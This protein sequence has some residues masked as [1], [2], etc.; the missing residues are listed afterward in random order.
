MSNN[1]S[2]TTLVAKFYGV[3]PRSMQR[4]YKDYLSDFKS[5]DQKS[6]ARNWML[7][8]QNIGGYLSLD[9]TAFSNGDLYTIITNK[10]AKGK[11][12]AIIAMVK[13]TK[14]ETVIN[15]LRKIPLKQ[16]SKV[17]E[18]TLDMAGNMGLI[19]KK[20][21][22]NATLVIDRFHVQKLA[23]DA[24]QEIR[25]K[26]RW[27]AIDLENDAIEKARSKSLKFT[28]EL[29]KNGDT[30]K[31]L[32]ARSRYLLYKSS[33]KW[34]KNQSQRAEVLF[35]RYPD[36][37]KAYNLCQNLSWIFNNSKDKTS[38]LIRLAKWDEK[39][40]KAE[41][42]SFNTIARTMSIHYKNILNYFD[43]RSTNASAES[44]NA[45]IKAFRAQFR[46]VRNID[47][48]LFRLASIYA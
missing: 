21:F 42:K 46:G 39:V 2:C 30:L 4:Q 27:D 36:L 5:W 19:V 18:V 3:N 23:L 20:S 17:K 33:S 43:N 8:P 40:R 32:L 26:H 25:I 38:A 13:G 31:Q 45:K 28:P 10:S 7:F 11:T 15:I 6:H 48:F 37:E 22:P 34:T 16:R 47:F 41:F 29:L 44:F 35:Q 24:L 12:G 9:E 14:A 1:A